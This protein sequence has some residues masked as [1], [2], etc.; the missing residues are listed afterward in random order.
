MFSLVRRTRTGE[1]WQ[2]RPGDPAA[3]R[4]QRTAATIED[5]FSEDRVFPPTDAFAGP[6][7]PGGRR[8]YERAEADWTGIL[9]RAGRI[10]RLV[11]STW[12]TVLAWDL[13]FARWFDG[14][15]A[16]RVA[17]I[18][19]TGTSP[20]GGVTPS[21]STGRASRATPPPSPTPSCSTTSRR[22]A[23]VLRARRGAGRPGGHLH[24]HDPRAAGGHAGLHPHRGR[25]FGGVRRVL[26]GRIARPHPRR[27][28]AGG[29]DR[30]RRLPPGGAGRGS[31][32]TWTW[33]CR[34][35]PA[36]DHVVVARRI[37]DEPRC[38]NMEPGRDHWWHEF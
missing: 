20:P 6:G 21:P 17:T 5:Y 38:P 32:R 33:P 36:M 29:D 1:S 19:S 14:G 30:R 10:P 37:G 4:C 11:P 28:G 27:P 22:F 8:V 15:T 25:A 35:H 12:D 34:S 23:N 2:S 24:A 7:G 26:V 9:G 18:A 13:P 31:R 3:G 16:Q